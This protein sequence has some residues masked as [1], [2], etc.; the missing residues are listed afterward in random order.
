MATRWQL[1]QAALIMEEQYNV[2]AAEKKELRDVARKA[3][4]FFSSLGLHSCIIGGVA[5]E[6]YGTTRKPNVGPKFFLP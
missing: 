4:S 6:A 1:R 5:C 3:V 2:V